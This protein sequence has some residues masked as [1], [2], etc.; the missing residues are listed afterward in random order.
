[1]TPRPVLYTF[2]RCPYAMRARWAVQVSALDVELR[3]I[4]L[5][6]KP[7]AMLVASPKGTVP[8]L[9]LPDGQVIDESLDVM[10]W[11]LAQHDPEGWL[12]PAQGTLADMLALIEACER[13]FKPHLDR[14]KYPARYRAEWG[15][16]PDAGDSDPLARAFAAQH[17]DVA[18]GFLSLLA[19]RLEGGAAPRYLFGTRPAL[20]DFA[21]A[22]F[23]R[24]FARHDAARFAQQATPALVLWLGALLARPDFEAVMARQA[25]WADTGAR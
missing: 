19:A 22:P 2:R 25:V 17:F 1:M 16:A 18:Q 12:T 6:A 7:A 4:T 8:V 14:Y 15:G 13:D 20:A 9:V 3:E 10:R 24:Q 11:A 23:V 5:R 21:I